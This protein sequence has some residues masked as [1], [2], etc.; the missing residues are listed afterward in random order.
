MY[1]DNGRNNM[2]RLYYFLL[3][4]FLSS[5]VFLWTGCGS[6]G[7]IDQPDAR[8]QPETNDNP[9]PDSEDPWADYKGLKAGFG[10]APIIEPGD[11]YKGYLISG[12]NMAPWNRTALGVHDPIYAVATVIDDGKKRIGIVAI[13]AFSISINDTKIIRDAVCSKYGIDHLIVHSVHNH[14][15]PDNSGIYSVL[16]FYDFTA[17]KRCIDLNNKSA[18]EAVRQAVNNL[19]PAQMYTGEV[20]DKDQ[21]NLTDDERIKLNLKDMKKLTAPNAFGLSDLRPPFVTD[22]GLRL[23]VFKSPKDGH[24]IGTIVN[25]SNHVEAVWQWNQLI[26]A[27]FVGYMR[28]ALHEKFGGETMFITG[29]TGSVSTYVSDPVVFYDEDAGK[30]VLEDVSSRVVYENEEYWGRKYPYGEFNKE[31]FDKAE[32]LG[33]LLADTVADA[34]E[35]GKVGINTSPE[36]KYYILK[37]KINVVNKIYLLAFFAGLLDRKSYVTDG[38]LA[39]E[40]ELNV[41]KI[42]DLLMLTL[43]AELYPEIAVG[44]VR[45]PAEGDYSSSLTEADLKMVN[46][47]IR[48][49]MHGK[50]NMIMNLGNDHLGYL[51]PKS[52]WDENE[53]FTFGNLRAPYGEENSMS[54]D[55]ATMIYGYAEKLLEQAQE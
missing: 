31:N 8:Y 15:V 26:S 45:T 2:N 50:V 44:G 18:I 11:D 37:D 54:P 40:T 43:P 10:R 52:Q 47:P 1:L 6:S 16:N 32:A 13:D 17:L 25:W 39:I 12:F 3:L 27:D 22:N 49:L 4:V 24:L 30:Y 38:K 53:P 41:L 34:I 19:E 21:L 29:N 42:G 23:A 48:N 51:I 7:S 35:S 28:D 36:I 33:N 20:L 14:D 46:V 9:Y 5:A 55:A